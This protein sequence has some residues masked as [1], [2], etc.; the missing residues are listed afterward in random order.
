LALG[1]GLVLICLVLALN[2]A[3]FAIRESALRRF[4]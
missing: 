4:G 2:A 1:L 3:A